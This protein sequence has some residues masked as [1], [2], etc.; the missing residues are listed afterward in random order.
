MKKMNYWLACCMAAAA[1]TVTFTACSSDD[2]PDYAA[3]TVA[4]TSTGS[5]ETIDLRD[6]TTYELP[7]NITSEAG[8]ASIV[9]RDSQ[10]NEWA[11]QTS[12]TN[13]NSVSSVTLDLSECTETQL[14]LLSVVATAKDGK[15][16]T[17]S[18]TYSLNV[19]AP[20]MYVTIGTI[21][22]M[23]DNAN[24]NLTISRGVKKLSSA[25]VYLN[26]A[27]VKEIDLTSKA[28]DKKIYE[29]V[30]LTGLNT[31]KNP[32]KV[33]V[34]DTESSSSAALTKEIDALRLNKLAANKITMN[35]ATGYSADIESLESGNM[36]TLICEDGENGIY[37]YEY[38]TFSYN[39]SNSMV[40]EISQYIIIDNQAEMTQS[41]ENHSYTFSYNEYSELTSVS[42][43]GTEIVTDVVYSEDGISSYKYNGTEYTAQYTNGVRVDCLDANMSG[44]KFIYNEESDEANPLYI[45]NLPAII[46]STVSGYPV[47]ALYS[48]YLFSGFEGGTT[49]DWTNDTEYISGYTLKSTSFTTDDA[50][51]SCQYLFQN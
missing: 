25:K 1:M 14:L 30:S 31:G 11:N 42:Y 45:A 9:V 21:A 40:S 27:L 46:P 26:D 33:E 28:S 35:Y 19:Y 49:W 37:T 18:G 12:F 5:S 43:D 15:V 24:M 41:E 3:P 36:L 48:P 8:L 2:D 38:W 16:T 23:S 39:E 20:A 50:M 4:F 47:Q 13:P 34:Y 10:G 44:K 51:Y 7:V 22:T 6:V 17:S 29:K 32:V